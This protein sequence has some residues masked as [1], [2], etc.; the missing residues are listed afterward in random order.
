MANFILIPFILITLL[1]PL[2]SLAQNWQAWLAELRQEALA[3][4][5]QPAVF[6]AAFADVKPHRQV[7]NLDRSQPERRLTYLQYRNSRID[8]YRIRLGVQEFNKNQQLLYQI[9]RDFG[10][11]PCF[12]VALW[13]L[14]SSYGRF[15]GNFPV[16]NSLATLAYDGRRSEFFRKELL[17]A[18][19]ILNDGH[20]DLTDFKGEWAGA[21]GH[22]QFLPSSWYNFAVDYNGDGKK[23]IWNSKTDALASIANYLS[24]NGWQ[25]HGALLVEVEA[26]YNLENMK[27]YEQALPIGEWQS[28]GVRINNMP[29]NVDANTLAY[30]VEPY[31]GPTFLVFNNFRVLMRY[32]NSTFYAGSVNYLASSIC[33]KVHFAQR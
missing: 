19:Q 24:Q 27:G 1:F 25:T 9:N 4:G 14:E 2:A 30:L 8:P 28:L 33:Q 12:V 11:N 26:P 22:P 16:I 3:Q 5:I 23:D 29:A 31:G 21:S 17:Y 18:L 13:G 32:N 6:D 7:I 15:R 20:V 10:V